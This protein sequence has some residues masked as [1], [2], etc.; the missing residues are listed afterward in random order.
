MQV[1]TLSAQL[2]LTSEIVDWYQDATSV[3]YGHILINLSPRTVDRL[4]YCTNRIHS[5]KSLYPGPAEQPKNLDDEHKKSL[6]SPSVSILFPQL[7]AEVF[8][9]SL[10]QKISSGFFATA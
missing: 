2:G 8:L 5:L 3:P 9:F 6:Y 7:H 1:F 10:A 4:R